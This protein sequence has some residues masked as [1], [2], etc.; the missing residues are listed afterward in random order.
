MDTPSN[1]TE[2]PEATPRM[3][4]VY[5]QLHMLA[6]GGRAADEIFGAGEIIP[7][8]WDLTSIHDPD[9][10]FDT[11]K[12]LEAFVY[13]FNT[14]HTWY[15]QDQIPPCW[16]EHPHL[17]RDIST[18]ADQR[19]TAGDAPTSTLLD[20][21]HRYTI[22]NFLERTHTARQGCEN[23]HT[24]WPGQPA[25]TRHIN[26]GNTTKRNDTLLADVNTLP[27]CNARGLRALRP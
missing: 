22:P 6:I 14:Q 9:L 11:W 1:L 26:Q 23:S 15:S 27:R 2:F 8:P 10:R 19:R 7:R 25:H 24:P 21:W 16:P 12:W 17:V 13:W 5:Q 4:K 3:A 20:E 18:L